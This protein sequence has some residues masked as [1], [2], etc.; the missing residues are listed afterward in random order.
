LENDL[1]QL[2]CYG[3]DRNKGFCVHCGG[4]SETVD[5]VPSK[6]FLEE[7]YPSNLMSSPA[8]WRC[9]NGFSADEEYLAC[10]LECI[11]VG[12]V[13][14]SRMR[15]KIE[16]I[17]GNSSGLVTKLRRARSEGGGG[18][19]W[20][21]EH[22]RARNIVLKLARCHAAYELNEPEL[23]EPAV[24]GFRPLPSFT[25]EERAA[26]EDEGGCEQAFWPEVG[27]RAMQRMLVVGAN[28]YSEGWFV[29]QDGN[30][31]FQVYQA[32]NTTVKIV[33]REYLACEVA[34]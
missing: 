31:R 25:A 16:R 19:T 1:Q 26:F 12:D 6:V 30:Y 22:H 3:D 27:T 28:A 23:G 10:L 20:A 15:P 13:D 2:T 8:C 14:P 24:V 9:N 34:W 33:I 21:V 18:T 5:H 29:V 11:V 17:L 4:P 7:P 32:P